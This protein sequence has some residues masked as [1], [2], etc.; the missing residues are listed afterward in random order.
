MF[1][2]NNQASISIGMNITA[3]SLVQR[4]TQ[5]DVKVACLLFGNMLFLLYQSYCHSKING[6]AQLFIYSTVQVV[7]L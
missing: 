3:H 2:L 5:P 4:Q 6:C 7:D 1:T